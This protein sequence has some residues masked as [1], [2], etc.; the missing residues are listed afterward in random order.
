MSQNFADIHHGRPTPNWPVYA[1]HRDRI[2]LKATQGTTFTDPAFVTRWQAAA[3][4]GL[5]RIAYHYLEPDD[6]G[7]RDFDHFMQVVQAAGGLGSDDW[8]C[9]DTEK[10]V[11]TPPKVHPR[12][13]AATV[14]FVNRASQ[15]GYTR[16]LVYSY[17]FYLDTAN[18]TAG[19][20][21]PGWRRL[22]VARYAAGIPDVAVPLPPGWDRLTQV[23]ARQYSADTAVDGIV[24][25]GDDSRILH[26]WLKDTP[27]PTPPGGSDMAGYSLA[28]DPRGRQFIIDTI[29]AAVL[30][31]FKGGPNGSFPAHLPDPEV[32]VLD[33]V[34]ASLASIENEVENVSEK[35]DT[36]LPPV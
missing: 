33:Q 2:A 10:T 20:L 13:A 15:L 14:E 1:A 22:W 18:I 19:M 21:P 34:K 3:R 7:A 26:D 9:L 35:V 5:H 25:T 24:G 31:I 12:A 4:A 8:L 16:G 36:L 32:P 29:Q 11:G 23:V 28:D 30:A 6:N 27:T 17:T